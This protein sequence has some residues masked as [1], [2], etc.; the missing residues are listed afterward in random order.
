M[1]MKDRVSHR[2]GVPALDGH[3]SAGEMKA[4][5]R[6]TGVIRTVHCHSKYFGISLLLVLFGSLLSDLI[7]RAR[8]ATGRKGPALSVQVALVRG[9]SVGHEAKRKGPEYRDL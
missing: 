6:S 8:T 5:P 4:I 3:V 2:V 1:F 7:R 9:R